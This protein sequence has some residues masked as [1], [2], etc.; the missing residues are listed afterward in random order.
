MCAIE[1]SI[2]ALD[3][4][5]E[6]SKFWAWFPTSIVVTLFVFLCLFYSKRV[7]VLSQT[8][9]CAFEVC[10]YSFF[11]TPVLFLSILMYLVTEDLKFMM[12]FITLMML[13]SYL[14]YFFSLF[15]ERRHFSDNGKECLDQVY[16]DE[17][18][19][20][21]FKLEAKKKHCE[22]NVLFIEEYDRSIIDENQM[23]RV[24][25]LKSTFIEVG[26]SFEL[27]LPGYMRTHVLNSQRPSI[28]DFK[29]VRNHVWT[30][31][32]QNVLQSFM[33]IIKWT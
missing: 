31:L 14:A 11:A 5:S 33:K 3:A 10:F 23:E 29:A 20:K 32:V 27:N 18:L 12:V 30:L 7:W 17:E 9:N 28:D 19:W 4:S 1:G 13:Y 25:Y 22:E 21:Q 24:E 2:I 8:S 16:L 15:R 26:S 6:V